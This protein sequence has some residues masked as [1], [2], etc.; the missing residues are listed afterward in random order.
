MIPGPTAE[1]RSF[2]S[3]VPR[4]ADAIRGQEFNMGRYGPAQDYFQDHPG[5][6]NEVG[7]SNAQTSQILNWINGKRRGFDHPES[8]GRQHRR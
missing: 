6:L 2:E 5:I 4:L 3:Q 7:L 1:E 8:G